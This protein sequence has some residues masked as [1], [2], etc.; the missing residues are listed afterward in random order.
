[1]SI[2]IIYGGTRE[3][4]NT[5]VLTEAAVEGL[6]VERIYLK[7]YTI[8][9]I[10]DRRHSV[11]GF[12]EMND[13]YHSIIKQIDKHEI[14]IF[15]TPI[16]W[17]SMSGLMKNFID[18]WSQTLKESN[19][20]FKKKMAAKK[21]YVIAVGGDE[22]QVKGLPMIQQFNYIFDFV[23]VSFEGYILGHAN[24]PGKILSDINSLKTAELI[25]NKLRDHSSL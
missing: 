5:E 11:D 3:N 17:Y 6:N 12:R 25:L 19:G 10:E 9:P 2:M 16:Y 7:D 23:G 13:D 8:L 1:M 14:I 22:P 21:A 24:R 20:D 18:R 4:G 15:A